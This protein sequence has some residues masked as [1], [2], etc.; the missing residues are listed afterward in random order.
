M[1]GLTNTRCYFSVQC[2]AI[3]YTIITIFFCFSN[4]DTTSE[5][6]AVE[7]G[8]HFQLYPLSTDSEECNR[9]SVR[10]NHLWKDSVCAL[11][12]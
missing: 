9:F 1:C 12:R 8:E 4:L 6:I 11:S 7:L 3:N 5:D 2:R 10:R